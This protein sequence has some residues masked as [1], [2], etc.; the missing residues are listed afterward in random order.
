MCLG[1]D[2]EKIKTLPD[3]ILSK[4][5]DKGYQDQ[6]NSTFPSKGNASEGILEGGRWPVF[7]TPL[8][9]KAAVEECSRSSRYAI[10]MIYTP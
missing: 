9:H 10:L 5:E 3:S 4:Q 8:G 7:L 6:A 2:G 1:A